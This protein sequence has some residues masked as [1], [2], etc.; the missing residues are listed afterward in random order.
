M[1]VPWTDLDLDLDLDLDH[2]PPRNV[3]VTI[4]M[5]EEGSVVSK[6]SPSSFMRRPVH[7]QIEEKQTPSQVLP[8]EKRL[9]I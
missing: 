3:R 4:D 7:V 9:Q 6:W 5:K 1:F 2:P 8:H